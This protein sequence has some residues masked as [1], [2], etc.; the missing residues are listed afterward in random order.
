[1]SSVSIPHATHWSAVNWE[2]VQG[3]ANAAGAVLAGAALLVSGVAV[4]REARRRREDIARLDN[5]A[6]DA[7]AAQ[8]SLIV[9]A[10]NHSA[11]GSGTAKLVLTNF[12]RRP[13]FDVLVWP[14]LDGTRVTPSDGRK[15][16]AVVKQMLEPGERLNVELCAPHGAEQF[17][18]AEVELRD[19]LGLR[20][21]RANNG[22]P[23][24]I[25]D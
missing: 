5:A 24:R 15:V 19:S 1:V 13:V 18:S 9:V 23:E 4:K 11:L 25:V 12:S 8:A 17:V 20:W 2:M 16:R 10:D 14:F 7:A 22:P 21:R 3:V 6:A